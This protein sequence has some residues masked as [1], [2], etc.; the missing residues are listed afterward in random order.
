MET[1][2]YLFKIMVSSLVNILNFQYLIALSLIYKRI[3]IQEPISLADPYTRSD[4]GTFIC[5]L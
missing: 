3:N 4:T 1:V 5:A 2:S